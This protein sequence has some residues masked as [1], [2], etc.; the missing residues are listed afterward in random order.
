MIDVTLIDLIKQAQE[1]DKAAMQMLIHQFDPLLIKYA[2]QLAI[3]FDDAKQELVLVFIQLIQNLKLETLQNTSN[4]IL[5]S[6]IKKSIHHASIRISKRHK[7]PFVEMSTD[8]SS[9]TLWERNH[10]TSDSYLNLYID[11]IKGILTDKEFSIFYLH[12]FLDIPIEIAAQSLQ[13]SRRSGFREKTRIE[14]KLKETY[15]KND[16]L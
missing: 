9:N 7:T 14:K 10:K 6:Y 8:D 15:C 2:A 5:A 13:I 3:E 1:K 12:Y 4:G 16:F 11:E